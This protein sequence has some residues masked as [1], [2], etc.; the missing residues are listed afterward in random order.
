MEG[1]GIGLGFI[2]VA[3]VLLIQEIL[4]KRSERNE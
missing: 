4:D 1:V 2:L 3:L